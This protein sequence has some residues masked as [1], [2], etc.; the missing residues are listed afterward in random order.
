M[1]Y[2]VSL[3]GARGAVEN[4]QLSPAIGLWP[5]HV[6]FFALGLLMYYGPNWWFQLV[7]RL[8]GR[9]SAEAGG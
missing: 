3:N 2:L 5:V 6:L 9:R 7:P 4:E 8:R 1:M